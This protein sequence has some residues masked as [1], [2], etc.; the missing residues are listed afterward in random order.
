MYFRGTYF[1]A[2]LARYAYT[3]TFRR[4]YIASLEIWTTG[5]WT[6]GLLDSCKLWTV[7]PFD[8]YNVTYQR[9]DFPVDSCAIS[10]TAFLL[11]KIPH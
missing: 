11:Q 9:D 10:P 5:L 3:I 6:D 2:Q 7:G 8:N 4:P 1:L